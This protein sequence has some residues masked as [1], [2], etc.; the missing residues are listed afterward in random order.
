MKEQSTRYWTFLIVLLGVSLSLGAAR[1]MQLSEQE[2]LQ[3]GF[4]KAVSDRAS[5]F[6]RE[7][8]GTL[9]T[10]YTLRT[11]F[12]PQVIP[13]SDDFDYV[14]RTSRNR[15]KDIVALYWVSE[16]DAQ[17][18]ALF[19]QDVQ[20]VNGS[21]QFQVLQQDE[22]GLLRPS[23]QVKGLQRPLVY[24]HGGMAQAL[25][26][27]IDLK[28]NPSIEDL[29]NE[30]K[31]SGRLVLSSGHI[32]LQDRFVKKVAYQTSL[33]HAALAIPLRGY[34]G[35]V[36]G[37][38]VGT[39]NLEVSFKDA[40][41]QLRVAGIDMKLWDQTGRQSPIL[42]HHHISR[43]RLDVDAS[44]SILTPIY[45]AGNRE[46]F[47]EGIPSYYYFNNRATW[48]PQL[49]FLI[50][51]AA[52][53]LLI[54][55]FRS[56][57]NKNAR[58]RQESSQ[59]M[60]SNQELAVISRTDALTGVANRRYF[61]ETLDNEWKRA[62]RNGTPLTLIMV[63]V[64][65]FKLFNDYYGHV[66]GDECIYTVAQTLKDMMSR[67]MDLVARY[68][69]EE[70]TILLPDTNEHAIIL[71]EQCR[72]AIEQQHIPHAASK[73]SPYVTISMGIATLKPEQSLDVLELILQ[74]DRALYRAKERGRNQV[75]QAEIN[76]NSDAD[77]L[78][79]PLT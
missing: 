43:T 58:I 54:F 64:D 33:V 57:A 74:A 32:D 37:Y 69:G 35:K 75:V 10:L 48:L 61:D 50:G 16:I 40:L 60:S 8:N 72:K 63:D 2:Q 17:K 7:L 15:H 11:L 30:A 42:L 51:L 20:R 6:G 59:L 23:V 55:T 19:E 62:L 31:T 44:R 41:R 25:P 38:I 53:G 39:I 36:A 34:P 4:E 3:N 66:E 68:G 27:G 49:V 79:P 12:I 77:S 14:A 47:L 67:P 26:I 1:L 24:Y 45:P 18:R 22:Q 70:F 56:M 13:K 71:A 76:D 9:E 21:S 29:L 73:V 52:T 5:V 65:C 28:N 46:W 78:M